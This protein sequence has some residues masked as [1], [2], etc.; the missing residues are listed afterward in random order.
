V[1]EFASSSRPRRADA[2]RSAAGVLAAAVDLF[3]RRPD[4]SMDE[5]AA[6]AGVARQTVYAHYPSRDALVAAVVE[7]LTTESAAALDA[8]DVTTG[9]ALDGLRRWA[10]AAWS[11]IDR[12]PVLLALP[13]AADHAPVTRRLEELVARGRR[14]GEIDRTVPA[15]WLVTAI[16]SLGHAAGADVAAGRRSRRE[17]G[18]LFVTSVTR[19]AAPSSSPPS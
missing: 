17:A 11:V 18:R 7:H 19:L 16:V 3:G 12:Y 4:A 5:V 9:S 13:M 6:A 10:E 2:R 15:S 14:A 1:S 8:V